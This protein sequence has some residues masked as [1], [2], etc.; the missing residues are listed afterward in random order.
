MGECSSAAGCFD[1]AGDYL[2]RFGRSPAANKLSAGS[3]FSH[4]AVYRGSSLR[5]CL[6]A[7]ATIP[8]VVYYLDK[9]IFIDSSVSKLPRNEDSYKIT[10]PET[11][12]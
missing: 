2:E 7:G 4:F 6:T 10:S 1:S 11:V 9:A 8:N 5:D 3:G 12:K